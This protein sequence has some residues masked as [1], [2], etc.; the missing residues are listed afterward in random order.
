MSGE[1]KKVKRVVGLE[2]PPGA[3]VP[4]VILKGAGI[5]A[6]SVLEAA[7]KPQS[8]I[9]VVKDKELL[10]RLYR[11][12]IDAPIDPELFELVAVLLV[13]LYMVDE[14]MLRDTINGAGKQETIR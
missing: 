9:K 11:L 8:G 12:P 2:C 6:E 3:G 7:G 4:R 14:K 1:E 5:T 10:D 13:H